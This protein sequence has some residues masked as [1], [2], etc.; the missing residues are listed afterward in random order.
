M[1]KHFCDHCG[2]EI[3]GTIYTMYADDLQYV[4]DGD[5]AGHFI[6]SGTELCTDCRALHRRAHTDYDLWFFG[7][8]KN[9]IENLSDGYHT[10]KSLYWQRLVL[11]SVIVETFGGWKSFNHEDGQPCFG[12]GWFIVG[13]DTPEGS[14]TYHFQE[15]H[16]ETF[17]CEILPN[18]KHWDGHTDADVTRLWSLL[19]DED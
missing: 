6:G 10:F 11:F 8:D 7:E 19:K 3:N 4:S 2:K 9:A 12:G 18:A 15:E 5:G 14:Y 1:I 17:N 16:W 13:V